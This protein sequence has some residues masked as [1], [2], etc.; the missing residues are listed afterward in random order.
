MTTITYFH[1]KVDA[2]T[3]VLQCMATVCSVLK[4]FGHVVIGVSREQD[5]ALVDKMVS[6]F[7]EHLYVCVILKLLLSLLQQRL[8]SSGQTLGSMS[9][10]FTSVHFCHPICPSTCYPGLKSTFKIIIA[11]AYKNSWRQ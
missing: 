7:F 10:L 3:K 6:F 9:I 1:V 8:L 11:K 2:S 5:K 4:Y